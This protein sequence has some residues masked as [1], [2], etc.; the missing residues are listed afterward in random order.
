MASTCL[1]A[2]YYSMSESLYHLGIK[3]LIRDEAGHILLLQVNPEKLKNFSGD[4]YWDIPGGRVQEGDSIE[5]TLQREILEETG[6][7]TIS[8]IVPMGMV[9]S[10]IRI[11]VNESD[12]GL[13]LSVYQCSLTSPITITLSDEHI[14]WEWFPVEQ[15]RELLAVKYPKE[16]LDIIV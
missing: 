1:T 16:F 10:N 9:L 11:P 15:A 8:N 5:D 2:Y 14:A 7:K 6:I 13:I 3:A 12:V 4:P